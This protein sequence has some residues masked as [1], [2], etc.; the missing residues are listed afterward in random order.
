MISI[1][2]AGLFAWI[3]YISPL[4]TEVAKLSKETVPVIMILIAPTSVATLSNV[5]AMET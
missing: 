3:S 1:G 4:V 2:T 5:C